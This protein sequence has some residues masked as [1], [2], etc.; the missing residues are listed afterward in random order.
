MTI[1]LTRKNLFN[2]IWERP[3]ANFRSAK[4]LQK[5]VSVHSSIHN[6]FNQERHLVTAKTSYLIAPLPWQSGV[7][8]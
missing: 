3:M 1:E 6:H 4:L 2:Q 7:N 8:T 5:F